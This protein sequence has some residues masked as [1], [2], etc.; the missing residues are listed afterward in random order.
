MRI[1]IRFFLLFIIL[2]LLFGYLA[3]WLWSPD[4]VLY[5]INNDPVSRG[6]HIRIIVAITS[7]FFTLL[8]V[9]V[10]LFKDEILGNFKSVEISAEPLCETIEEFL[11]ESYG[12]ED[13]SVSKYYNQVIFQNSGNVNALD[14]ELLVKRISFKG[15]NDLIPHNINVSKQKVLLGGQDKTYIPKNGG[16]REAVLIEISASEDPTGNKKTQ[17]TI[18]EN[19]VP[20]KAGTW[21]VEYC[22]NMSNATLKYYIFEIEWSDGCWHEGK[23]RM[24]VKTK[25]K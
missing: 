17:L 21:T 7:S 23:N 14:C 15:K 13:P 19:Q 2:A 16:R 5:D 24:Q 22:L 4:T 11:T 3:G 1:R 12:D 8:T 10:A 25:R 9:I 18:A 6:E 20:A